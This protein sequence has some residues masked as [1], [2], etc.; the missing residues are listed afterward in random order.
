MVMVLARA[1]TIAEVIAAWLRSL[2]ARSVKV[3]SSVWQD[4]DPNNGLAATR[5]Q[6]L[7]AAVIRGDV[8]AEEVRELRAGYER[9][10]VRDHASL[11]PLD[12]TY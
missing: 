12:L 4:R 9:A 6:Q 2:E 3:P 5:V 7:D 11:P 10:R 1:T 8:S